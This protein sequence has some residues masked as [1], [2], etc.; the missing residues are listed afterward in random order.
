MDLITTPVFIAKVFALLVCFVTLVSSIVAVFQE[1]KI[2]KPKN[3]PSLAPVGLLK[4]FIFNLLWISLCGTGSVL[5]CCKYIL[6]GFKSDIQRESHCW[7]ER[8]AA[9]LCIHLVVGT[10]KVVGKENL[11]SDEVQIPAPV[12]VANHASQIDLGAVYFLHRQFKWIAKQSVLYVPGVGLTM[13]LSQH[14]LIDRVKGKNKKSVATLFDKSNAA[15]QGGTPMFLFPQGTRAMAERR[16]LKD[17][18]FI[19]AQTNKSSLV[20][21]SI[22]IPLNAWNSFYP[23]SRNSVPEVVVTVHKPIEVTGT[24]DRE[25]LKKK[26]FDQIYSCLPS[27]WETDDKKS[28]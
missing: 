21:I 28:K 25:A 5:I 17:G 24:E 12:Y 15:V 4:V 8:E 11:P 23:L 19:I 6:S 7:V 20:P 16:P 9:I 10:V 18:A 3:L 22:E 13:Y 2:W 14:V 26:C 27:I 1:Q